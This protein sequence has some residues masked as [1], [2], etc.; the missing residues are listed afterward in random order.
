MAT[1]ICGEARGLS[2]GFTGRQRRAFRVGSSAEIAGPRGDRA[3][4][5]PRPRMPPKHPRTTSLDTPIA[6]LL[7]AIDLAEGGERREAGQLASQ[8]DGIGGDIAF[9]QLAIA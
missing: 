3:M 1:P 6:V 9:V 4:L 2:A 5:R 7:R 8:V